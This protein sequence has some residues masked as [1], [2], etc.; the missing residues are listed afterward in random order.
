M[1]EKNQNKFGFGFGNAMFA[2]KDLQDM[3]GQFDSKPQ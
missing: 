2:M 3:Y 1:K